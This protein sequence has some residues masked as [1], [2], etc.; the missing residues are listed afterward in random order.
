[1][2]HW[3]HGWGLRLKMSIPLAWTGA[4]SGLVPES[5]LCQTCGAVLPVRALPG[6]SR[7]LYWVDIADYFM[8]VSA[9]RMAMTLMPPEPPARE[10]A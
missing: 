1:M 3:V 7:R 2:C 5:P 10:A 6:G 8:S 9:T 4:N